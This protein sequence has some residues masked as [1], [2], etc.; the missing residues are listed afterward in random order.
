[1]RFVSR[2]EQFVSRS[3]VLPMRASY[4]VTRDDFQP[5]AFRGLLIAGS[6]SIL[7]WGICLTAFWLL[8]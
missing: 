1:M 3:N 8:R 5:T 2:S 6:V 4:S 7:F